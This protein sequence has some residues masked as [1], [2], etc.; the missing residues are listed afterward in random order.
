M[1]PINKKRVIQFIVAAA[2]AFPVVAHAQDIREETW[3]AHVQTTYIWQKKPSFSAP[4]TGEF[5]LR[6]EREKAYT[7]S[8]TA[9]LGW[10][11]WRGGELYFDPEIVQGVPMSELRGLGGMTNGE[12]QKTSGPN[13]TLYRARLFL[14]QTWNLGGEKA[15][16]RIRCR[17]AGRHG[18]QAAHCRHC[19]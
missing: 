10:R 11:P 5:S 4:Y 7:F 3:N 18:R 15:G 1:Y 2:S 8:A 19:R 13:P 9:S 17:P 6:P 12:Q 14:R 16:G